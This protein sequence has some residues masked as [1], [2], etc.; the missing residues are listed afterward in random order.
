MGTKRLSPLEHGGAVTLRKAVSN[1]SMKISASMTV[2]I[3][4]FL[5]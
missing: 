2:S 4:Q 3:G 5:Q 1:R